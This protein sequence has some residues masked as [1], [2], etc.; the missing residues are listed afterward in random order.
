[1]LGYALL[2][3][4]ERE[5][6][7]RT[8]MHGQVLEHLEYFFKK[9]DQIESLDSLC[10]EEQEYPWEDYIRSPMALAQD[11]NLKTGHCIDYVNDVSPLYPNC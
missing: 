6:G 10:N 7:F 8:F 2:L 5:Y 3:A 9:V 1:M 4:M 11:D